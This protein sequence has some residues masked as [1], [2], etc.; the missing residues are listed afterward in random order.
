M[1]NFR[2]QHCSR[3]S[4][5]AYA[6]LDDNGENGKL[7]LFA[8]D[9]LIATLLSPSS[10]GPQAWALP[11][12]SPKFKI[13]LKARRASS[14]PPSPCSL[15]LPLTSET[16]WTSVA[17]ICLESICFEI[18]PQISFGA[19]ISF[20]L[21]IHVIHQGQI[22]QPANDGYEPEVLPPAPG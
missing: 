9:S 18:V 17:F 10:P 21:C 15:L 1:H 8:H 16:P 13:S 4:N 2:E 20:P 19:C 22:S 6:P 11:H 12:L 14:T 3:V 5:S 7:G